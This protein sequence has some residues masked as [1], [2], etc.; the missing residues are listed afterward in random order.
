MPIIAFD[1]VR[2][3]PM[4]NPQKWEM[5]GVPVV[6]PAKQILIDARKL[7]EKNWWDGSSK[8][9]PDAV[10]AVVAIHRV[11]GLDWAVIAA[12]NLLADVTGGRPTRFNDTHTKAEVL[13][14]FDYAI[15]NA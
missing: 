4:Y 14:A 10:C 9:A 15:A 6:S 11:G 8:C 13:Q 2:E 3:K 7:V 1:I 5:P 12:R